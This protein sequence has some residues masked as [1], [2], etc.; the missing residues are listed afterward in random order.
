MADMK[1]YWL[2]R[3]TGGENGLR[4]SQPLLEKHH[5]ISIGWSFIS[6]VELV[7]SVKKAGISAIDKAY[8]DE[9][10][11]LTN[12]RYSLLHFIKNMHTGDVVIV[13]MGTEMGVYRIEDEHVYTNSTIPEKYLKEN[14]IW[15]EKGELL[16]DGG[17]IDLGFYRKVSPIA[18]H[19]KRAQYADDD[20]Y[21]R[22]RARQTT[23][24]ISDLELSIETIIKSLSFT[25]QPKD[26]QEFNRWRTTRQHS[27][28]YRIFNRFEKQISSMSMAYDASRK[29]AYSNALG[30]KGVEWETPI[31]EVL[32]VDN[33]DGWTTKIWSDNM[34]QFDNLW[35]LNRLMALASYFETY[36][37]SIVRLSIESDP[38]LLVN[39]PHSVDG[40]QFLKQQKSI[41]AIEV[42][43]IVSSCTKGTWT[44]RTNALRRLLGQL[45]D[46]L[47]KG[48]GI[49]DEIRILRNK[50]GHAFGRNIRAARN[51]LLSDIPDMEKLQVH[52]F[53]RYHNT[54]KNIAKDLDK[55]IMREHIGQFQVLYYY[56]KLRDSIV[57]ETPLYKKVDFLKT[58]LITKENDCEASKDL[59][60][61]AINYYE[62]LK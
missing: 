1:Q 30:R 31:A 51:Y 9:D 4:L 56:H 21:K 41:K 39:S 27:W 5:L 13:P 54:V 3:I 48:I 17:T 11:T 62:A 60:K 34:N 29:Y 40:I 28:P 8:K 7:S 57:Q 6:S 14:N 2:H 18:T 43:K 36:I 37:D 15:Y 20:L 47:E 10:A 35:R 52:T 24:N 45:P 61:W 53:W 44:N 38:G 49:L 33:L 12:N 25:N 19:L 46:S 50:V 42:N 58:A 22:M 55:Q 32:Y 26:T 23:L 16:F 59:C